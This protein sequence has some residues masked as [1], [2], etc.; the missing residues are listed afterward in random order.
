MLTGTA[1][2]GH[3]DS[4]GAGPALFLSFLLTGSICTCA[5]LCYAELAAMVPV[6]GGLAPGVYV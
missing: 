1:A 5:A 2:V 3:S 4:P 6:A